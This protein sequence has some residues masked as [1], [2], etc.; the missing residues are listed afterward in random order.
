MS[1]KWIVSLVLGLPLAVL[2][3]LE[4]NFPPSP[5][6]NAD[7]PLLVWDIAPALRTGLPWNFRTTNDQLRAKGGMAPNTV[8]LAQL[9]A[10]GSG[11]FTS[12]NL[13]AMLAKLPGPSRSSTCARRIMV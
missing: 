8:G 7:G 5:P 4:Q 9:R 11:E 3:S 13:K 12:D 2:A 10:S 1:T 6:A